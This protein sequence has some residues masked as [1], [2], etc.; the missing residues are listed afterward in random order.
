MLVPFT[1]RSV[2][3]V[4]AIVG[5]T[6]SCF[7]QG[8]TL[9]CQVQIAYSGTGPQGIFKTDDTSAKPLSSEKDIS[10]GNFPQYIFC[11]KRTL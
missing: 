11:R 8:V 1:N 5:V 2:T 10:Y 7:G 4:I 6:D 3:D 9:Y